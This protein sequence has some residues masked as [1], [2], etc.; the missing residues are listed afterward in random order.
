M[1]CVLAHAP[2]S[3]SNEA[4]QSNAIHREEGIVDT[5]KYLPQFDQLLEL[6]RYIKEKGKRISLEEAIKTGVERNPKLQVAFA[7]IQDFEWQVIA[8]KRRWYPQLRLNN[9]TPFAGYTWGTFIE[10]NY[11]MRGRAFPPNNSPDPLFKSQQSQSFMMLPGASLEWNFFEPTRQPDI[12]AAN[13]LL[14]KQKYLFA[15]SA[16]NLILDIQ[17]SY[18]RAQR[19]QQLIE[20]F[21]AIY[22][23][24]KLELETLRAG[25]ADNTSTSLDVAQRQ[26]QLFS[27]LEQLIGYADDFIRDTA[28]LAEL[29][30]A[31][32]E[33]LAIPKDKAT[34]QGD[35]LIPLGK[36]ID[37]AI[38]QREE[39][40]ASLSAAEAARWRGIEA[41]RSY[42]PVF[43][44]T[45]NGFLE[46]DN[47]FENV[48][49]G[50]DPGDSYRRQNEWEASA[51]IGFT[52]S[53]FDGGIKA[54]QSS[55]FDAI[56][57]RF[58]ARAAAEE[59]RVIR[60]IESSFSLL[61]TSRIGISSAHE[62]Y[63][64]AN[65]AQQIARANY[66]AGTT[67]VTTIVQTMNQLARASAQVAEATLNYNNAV[68]EL[69]R[70]SATWPQHTKQLVDKRETELRL[71]PLNK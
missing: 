34:L 35:W 28:E 33:Q 56:S 55:S 22:E 9:G 61:K 70:Y 15:V 60:Q 50:T 1:L 37:Q 21:E 2:R 29:I 57:N 42:L 59:L 26:A 39:I 3:L 47:G 46:L 5:E 69:Y 40:L 30:S 24:N 32:A 19:S 64:N 51:G 68:A 10:D 48:D 49:N 31:E 53:I 66:N 62:A 7:A 23:I 16:R 36:T 54:A 4:A 18:Y 45:G 25:L 14:E 71:N 17:Q 52:W 58:K 20:S 13:E 44:L 11:G 8:A 41:I 6:K 38:S 63:K 43:G 67:G 65:L 12:N 27:Q